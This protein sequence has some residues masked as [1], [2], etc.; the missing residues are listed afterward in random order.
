MSFLKSRPKATPQITYHQFGGGKNEKFG[1]KGDFYFVALF[2]KNVGDKGLQLDNET[3]DKM[4]YFPVPKWYCSLYVH[5]VPEGTSKYVQWLYTGKGDP[6]EELGMHKKAAEQSADKIAAIWQ[7]KGFAQQLPKTDW[8]L[9]V[10]QVNKTG[11]TYDI[12]NGEAMILVVSD[13]V[14]KKIQVEATK[15]AIKDSDNP[16]IFGRVIKL[17]KDLLNKN[18]NDKYKAEVLSFVD[19]T[20]FPDFNDTVEALHNNAVNSVETLLE[21]V[22]GGEYNPEVVREYITGLT[23]M[24]WEAFHAKYNVVP[25]VKLVKSEQTDF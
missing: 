8:Y 23:G 25:D 4:A 1:Q 24:T 12:E 3:L 9:P 20:L 5:E 18:N 11:K 14:M 19:T 6:I 16:D 15:D 7:G 21:T 22:N 17:S 10:I 13:S 2:G